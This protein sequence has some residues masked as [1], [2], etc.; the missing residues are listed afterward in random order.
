MATRSLTQHI[1]LTPTLQRPLDEEEKA[2]TQM[3]FA[4]PD[5]QLR[6][7]NIYL[8]TSKHRRRGERRC[9]RASPSEIKGIPSDKR[10]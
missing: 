4:G 1:L 10:L 5:K 3:Y 7:V 6:D 9:R 8:F 2:Q